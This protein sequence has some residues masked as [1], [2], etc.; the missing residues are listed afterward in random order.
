MSEVSGHDLSGIQ[1]TA[2]HDHTADRVV[3][4]VSKWNPAVTES[5]FDGAVKT[6][7]ATGI[8]AENILRYN[9]PGS[10]E[11]PSAANLALHQHGNLDGVICLGCLIQGETRHFDFIA[12]AVAHGVMNVGLDHNKPVIF[13]VL[14]TNT[15][16]QAEARAG[17]DFGNKG[18][19]AAVALLEMIDLHNGH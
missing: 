14:T 15:Q 3:I 18:S 13:G 6:L 9:V 16:E 17:G 5:L 19:E 10:F 1:Y 7:L 12:D 4:V 11:L 2:S 8:R